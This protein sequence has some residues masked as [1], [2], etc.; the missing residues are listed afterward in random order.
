MSGT[1]IYETSEQ[2]SKE[3]LVVENITIMQHINGSVT[4]RT[5]RNVLG[6]YPIS[7]PKTLS[8]G[9]V[10]SLTTALIGTHPG[11]DRIS[12]R[13]MQHPFDEIQ[14][15]TDAVCDAMNRMPGIDVAMSN[16]EYAFG[17]S[18]ELYKC[19]AACMVT[20][21]DRGF[22]P[23]DLS[24][25]FL[26]LFSDS[27]PTDWEHPEIIDVDHDIIMKAMEWLTRTA[28]RFSPYWV[29]WVCK[30]TADDFKTMDAFNQYTYVLDT[31]ERTTE[32]ELRMGGKK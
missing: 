19:A 32:A 30:P 15:A 23:R 17:K 1:I 29:K 21:N 3:N 2:P 11:L 16:V 31:T 22:D 26:N 10:E 27:D 8:R 18:P 13:A 9:E 20:L 7:I 14:K 6:E 24:I 4:I 25:S 5:I 28:Q 12:E